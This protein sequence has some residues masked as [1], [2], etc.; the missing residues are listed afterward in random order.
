MKPSNAP[1]PAE[2]SARTATERVEP[3]ERR[4]NGRRD[5]PMQVALA[6]DE[7]YFAGLA[8]AI[9]SIMLANGKDRGIDF[10]VMDG[11]IDDASWNFLESKCSAIS[12][13]IRLRRHRISTAAFADFPKDSWGGVM[14]YARLFME[15]LIEEDEVIYFDSDILCFR[16]LRELWEEPMGDNL[17]AAC[18]DWGVQFLGED[19]AFELNE[20]DARRWYF[21]A[22]FMK[23][24]LD[25]WRRESVQA[26]TLALLRDFG[27]KC[28]WHDQTAL[29][30][31]CMGRV[32]YLDAEYNHYYIHDVTLGDFTEG[33]INIHFAAK[34]KPW[35]TYDLKLISNVV[36]RV[37]L[38]KCM[39]GWTRPRGWLDR[40]KEMRHHIAIFLM[41]GLGTLLIGTMNAVRACLPCNERFRALSQ[42]LERRRVAIQIIQ[43]VS[44]RAA[45]LENPE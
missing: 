20:E 21:N 34:T 7:P 26:R 32:R 36:W 2:G 29:N 11:G 15:T 41:N 31:L 10:H 37:Y 3:V 8:C 17:I 1:E 44:A 23:I 12:P 38:E 35:Q 25:G 16:D 30:T 24:N 19:C 39:P 9:F 6:A 42:W 22:G 28:R 33:R 13:H 4:G 27:G 5:G 14:T 45:S 18:R 43:W 40:I